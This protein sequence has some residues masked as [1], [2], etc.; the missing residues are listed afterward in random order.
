MFGWPHADV[1][2][3]CEFLSKAGYMGVKVFPPQEQI[4]STEPFQNVM[5]PWYFMYAHENGGRLV[6]SVNLTLLLSRRYQP[7][8]YKLEGRMGTRDELRSM[9]NTCRGLGVRVYADAVVNHMTGG[10]NDANPDH[11]NPNANCQAFGAKQS[12]LEGGTSPM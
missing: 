6:I 2:K 9:I 7:V 3:E 12:S 4:M 10:G 8:S 5:N 11:R 1:E